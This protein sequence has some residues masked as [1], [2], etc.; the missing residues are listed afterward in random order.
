MRKFLTTI[1]LAVAVVTSQPVEAAKPPEAYAASTPWNLDYSDDS[2]ALRRTFV[3]TDKMVLFELRQFQ[4]GDYFTMIVASKHFPSGSSPKIR[5]VPEPKPH[6]V[7]SGVPLIYPNGLVGFVWS[8]SFMPMT[9]VDSLITSVAEDDKLRE[10]RETAIQRIELS[11]SISPPIILTVGKMNRPMDGMRKCMDELLTHWGIDA[12]TQ[13]TLTRTAK[14]LSQG[15]WASIIQAEYPSAMLNQM[16]GGIVRV[17][18]IVGPD[19]R[20]QSCHIQ[21]PSQD[22]SFEKTA[23]AGMMKAS[24]FEPALDAAGKPTVSYFATTIIYRVN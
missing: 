12:T 19:G 3:H 13:R 23:C 2:C 9:K 15:R 10:A 4:P 7:K 18:M 17:R 16:K 1:L 21:V 14:P 6:E 11:G 8:D 24:R 20:A 5:F 22:P